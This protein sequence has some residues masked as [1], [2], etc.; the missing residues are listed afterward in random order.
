M[1]ARRLRASALAGKTD[2]PAFVDETADSYD[3]VIENEQR[4]NLRPIELALFVERRMAA[5][6]SQAEIARRL[7]KSR[8][9]VTFA[10]ALIDAPDW[11]M[12]LYRAGRCRGIRELYELRR[13]SAIHPERVSA[14]LQGRNFVSRGDVLSLREGLGLSPVV[15]P[16]T[17]DPVLAAH[18]GVG[19]K[20]ALRQPVVAS[21]VH[22]SAQ[23]A[24]GRAPLPIP[25][26]S[27][28]KAPAKLV[29]DL[30]GAPVRVWLDAAPESAGHVFVTPMRE[31]G[32]SGARTAVTIE[33]LRALRL[34]HR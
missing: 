26:T 10:S 22:E 34:V 24:R 18:A 33:A 30:E 14:W 11:L 19:K 31:G 7:G 1:G 8:S 2:I 21:A 9:Y 13:L 5:G 12:V 6:E 20:A 32:E 17:T 29:A 27:P 3:Q 4:E 25:E 16:S 23:E 28:R 15:D